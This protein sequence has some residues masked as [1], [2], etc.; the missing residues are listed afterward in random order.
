MFVNGSSLSNLRFHGPF[1]HCDQWMPSNLEFIITFHLFRDDPSCNTFSWTWECDLFID[2][3]YITPSH[4]FPKYAIFRIAIHSDP[5]T[6]ASAA[7]LDSTITP[8]DFWVNPSCDTSSWS[9]RSA[10]STHHAINCIS[11][12]WMSVLCSVSNQTR[13]QIYLY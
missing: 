3:I 5:S 9:W 8:R 4:S 10:L 12:K 11:W 6:I 13:R 7:K 2:H 1:T